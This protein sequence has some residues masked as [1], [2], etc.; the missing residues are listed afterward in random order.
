MLIKRTLVVHS[1]DDKKKMRTVLAEESDLEVQH[2]SR[3]DGSVT[4]KAKDAEGDG[5]DNND[6]V[7]AVTLVSSPT[8]PQQDVTAKWFE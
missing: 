4:S 8:M 5:D 2:L 6:E 1:D 3:P 7:I